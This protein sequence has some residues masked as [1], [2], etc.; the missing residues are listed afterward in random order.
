[1]FCENGW[2]KHDDEEEDHDE[3]HDDHNDYHD[4]D[5]DDAKEKEEE[6]GSLLCWGFVFSKWAN[7][8]VTYT[9]LEFLRLGRLFHECFSCPPNKIVEKT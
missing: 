6:D 4:D 1:M 5:H 7:S 9:C 3:D 8:R 2:N